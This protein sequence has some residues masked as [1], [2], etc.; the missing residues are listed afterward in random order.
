MICSIF[1]TLVTEYPLYRLYRFDIELTG[2]VKKE[3]S[4]RSFFCKQP[5]Y[6][7][8]VTLSTDCDCR[9]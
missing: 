9:K 1:R 2:I 7:L 5:V 4:L 6:E 3:T 8:Q